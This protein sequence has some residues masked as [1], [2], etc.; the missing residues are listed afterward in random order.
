MHLITMAHLGEAQGVIEKF[1][2]ERIDSDLFKNQDLVLVL[3]GE[4]PF[5][6]AIKTS[7]VLGKYPISKIINLGIAGALNP[8]LQIGEIYSIRTHYL[9]QDYKPSFRTFLNTHE[10][11]DCITSFE[12][13]LNP[14]KANSL[15]GV[16]AIVDREAWGSAYAAKSAGISF[17]SYK[18]ISDMAGTLGACEL[19]RDN[20]SDFSLKLALHLGKVLGH[21][22]QQEDIV[23]IPGFHFT[24]TSGH[25]FNT[26]LKKLC[27][28]YELSPEELLKSFALNEIRGAI[29]FPKDRTKF[30]L[31]RMESKLDPFRET[32]KLKKEEWARPFTKAGITLETDPNWENKEVTLRFS[33]TSDS[34]LK[35]K[36]EKLTTLSLASFTDLMEGKLDVE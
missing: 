2:L 6:A 33:V 27:I 25:R 10:G 17:E 4:G 35:T 21:K 19:V 9:V 36:L 24:F 20:A 11:Q 22:D 3:T 1:K 15:R 30:L 8:E 32:L 31:D 18:L 26:L 29:S 16:G 7:L 34:E 12:R 23:S 28:K 5:E 14:D 13:I